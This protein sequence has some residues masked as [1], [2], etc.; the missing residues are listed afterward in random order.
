MGTIQILPFDLVLSSEQMQSPGRSSEADGPPSSG[1]GAH[2][3]KAP[4]VLP[5][6]NWGSCTNSPDLRDMV[7]KHLNGGEVGDGIRWL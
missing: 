7:S 3:T 2:G 1:S 6:G 5:G 4:L